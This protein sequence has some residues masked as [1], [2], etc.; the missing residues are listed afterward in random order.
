MVSA[1]ASKRSVSE[2][3]SENSLKVPSSTSPASDLDDQQWEYE[4]NQRREKQRARMVRWRLGR[5][6]DLAKLS[7]Q[8]Q[9]LEDM[10]QCHIEA[11]QRANKL[12]S[13]DGLESRY[14]VLR[15][16]VI[17]RAALARE[18]A[19][20]QKALEPYED[21]EDA[22]RQ[23]QCVHGVEPSSP[24][25]VLKGSSELGWRVH[26]SDGSPSFHFHPYSSEEFNDIVNQEEGLYSLQN[27]CIVHVGDIL[28]WSVDYAPVALDATNTF[29]MAHA[30]FTRHLRCSLDFSELQ[31]TTVDPKFLPVLTTPST[32]FAAQG[33]HHVQ[34]T[35]RLNYRPMSSD[36]STVSSPLS[37]RQATAIAKKWSKTDTDPASKALWEAVMRE[38]CRREQQRR[39]MVR[40]RQKKKEKVADMVHERRRLEKE[41]QRRVLE[42]RMITDGVTPESFE[43]AFQLITIEKAA[44]TRDNLVLQERIAENIKFQNMM[45]NDVE[46]LMKVPCQDS[47]PTISVVAKANAK[48]KA[49]VLQDEGGWR[50][51][52]PNGEPSFHFHPFTREE[53]DSYVN[54]DDVVYAEGFP[55]TA[56]VGKLFGWRVDYAPLALNHDGIFMA[57]ARFTKRVCCS[58]DRVDKILPR[59]DKSL[60]PK[61]VI[62]RSWGHVQTGSFTCQELQNF[63][64]NAHVMVCNIPGE[65]NLRYFALAQHTRALRPD[66]KRMDLYVM[67]IAD[68]EANARNREAEGSQYNVDGPG[69]S[70]KLTAESCILTGYDFLL[71]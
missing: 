65:V 51:F 48:S 47:T 41:L 57:H 11:A 12:S 36:T 61:L 60:W 68:S 54:H 17:K 62:P 49:P 27:P 34:V 9:V 55:C 1:I 50:V 45:H 66:G 42:A 46:E 5:K 32:S 70:A 35:P 15:Q 26:F 39:R 25:S 69:A 24:L 67:T 18:N 14:H 31:L 38:Q 71:V 37:V 40:W 59:I 52:F 53:F 19:V 30:R 23:L 4:Q 28:G 16:L 44:L 2:S 3:V 10:L 13:N 22:I 7:Q 43:E 33:A 20:L 56:S 29:Y 21:F 6:Q 8:R 58:I 64:K 63:H